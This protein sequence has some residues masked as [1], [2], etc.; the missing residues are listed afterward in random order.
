MCQVGQMI[1][2]VQFSIYSLIFY[3][4][5]PSIIKEAMLK[6]TTLTVD[7]SISPGSYSSICCMYFETLLKDIW[8]LR[9]VMSSKSHNPFIFRKW[10]FKIP[11]YIFSLQP[12]LLLFRYSSLLLISKTVVYV[13][14][15][16][17]RL[18]ILTL[19]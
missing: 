9:T 13:F 2:L 16:L 7:S 6:S 19:Y 5:V 11:G 1:V 17:L 18:T 8:T 14:S 3:L 4:L 12:T 10:L 15:I